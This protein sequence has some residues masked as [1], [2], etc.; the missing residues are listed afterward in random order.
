M[1]LI[2]QTLMNMWQMMQWI[3]MKYVSV[4]PSFSSFKEFKGSFE[5]IKKEGFHPF[6]AFNSQSGKE[7]DRKRASN[8][9]SNEVIN[10]SKFQYTS[11][12]VKCVNYGVARS[13]SKGLRLNQ[14][15]FFFG[16][17]G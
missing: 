7:Y 11:Y 16:L 6:H 10:K 4:G 2:F 13:C 12:S 8:K 9:Y 15:H 14:C 17:R 1:I 3:S 5:R